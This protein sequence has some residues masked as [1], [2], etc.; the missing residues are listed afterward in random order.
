MVPTIFLNT[1]SLT[2]PPHSR[3]CSPTE[4]GT[5]LSSLLCPRCHISFSEKGSVLHRTNSSISAPEGSEFEDQPEALVFGEGL[6]TPSFPTEYNSPWTCNSCSYTLSSCQVSLYATRQYLKM[7]LFT[8]T[9]TNNKNGLPRQWIN[10]CGCSATSTAPT[11][12]TSSPWRSCSTTSPAWLLP[13]TMW[14]CRL[15]IGS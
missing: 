5:H 1:N 10:K 2:T 15:T 9:R 8:T 7:K 11:S 6:L 12:L 3:C 13:P 4:L 14:P